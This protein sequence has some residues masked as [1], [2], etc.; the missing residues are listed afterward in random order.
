M[1]QKRFENRATRR[2]NK[3]KKNKRFVNLMAISTVTAVIFAYSINGVASQKNL[4]G[5]ILIFM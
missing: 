2:N 3:K 4:L 1:I 5:E